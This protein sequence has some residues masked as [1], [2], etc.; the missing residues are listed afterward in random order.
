MEAGMSGRS[1][2]TASDEERIGLRALAKSA[3]RGEADR[4][5]AILLT[6]DGRRAE[7]IA[8]ALGVH[9]STVR[10][11]RG[12][13]ARGRVVALRRRKAPGRCPTIGPRAGLLAEAILR[14][15][16][17]HDGGCRAPRD[18]HPGAARRGIRP[19]D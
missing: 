2:L 15:D 4:A 18:A 11:W 12:R 13:F 19:A 7:E 10:G 16:A 8:V 3:Q 17:G 14:E 6:L 9:V 1:K 5:R